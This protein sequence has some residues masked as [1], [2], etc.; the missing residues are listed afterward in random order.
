VAI[1]YQHD[2]RPHLRRA[3]V[4]R[5]LRQQRWDDLHRHDGRA[6]VWAIL[7]ASLGVFWGLVIWALV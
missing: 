3:M 5:L 2:V 7:L 4:Y 1:T 6:R